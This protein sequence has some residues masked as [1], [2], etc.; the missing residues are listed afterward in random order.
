MALPHRNATRKH[1]SPA[2]QGAKFRPTPTNPEPHIRQSAGC[3]RLVKALHNQGTYATAR[4][5]AKRD[6]PLELALDLLGMPRRF[7]S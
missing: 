7:S 3:P 6:Y 1:T 5:L 4:H 2:N